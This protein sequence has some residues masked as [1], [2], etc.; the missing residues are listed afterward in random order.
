M[1]CILVTGIPAAG[2]STMAK[3][4]GEQLQLPVLSKD[5]IK[6]LLYGRGRDG[7]GPLLRVPVV[8]DVAP[9]AVR[10]LVPLQEAAV[11]GLAV[12]GQGDGNGLIAMAVQNS[13][14]ALPGSVFKVVL[15][16]TFPMPRTSWSPA[17]TRTKGPP[18]SLSAPSA[19]SAAA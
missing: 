16:W 5:G 19:A 1:F 4:L 17:A 11:D 8:D 18:P 12:S 14:Q 3:F 15:Q 10:A 7:G 13:R 2:K 6:E 9:V